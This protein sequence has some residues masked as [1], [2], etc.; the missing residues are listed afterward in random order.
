VI[1][2]WFEDVSTSE[3][4]ATGSVLIDFKF[5]LK[6][7]TKILAFEFKCPYSNIWTIDKYFWW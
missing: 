3:L 7:A 2:F 6:P 4:F 5:S 1:K